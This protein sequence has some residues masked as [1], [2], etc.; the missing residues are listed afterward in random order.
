MGSTQAL[1]AAAHH[2]TVN[3]DSLDKI[4]NNIANAGTPGYQ[5]DNALISEYNSKGSFQD[6]LSFAVN[7]ASIRDVTPGGFIPTG[8]S[9]DIALGTP[10]VYLSV[11]SSSG[12]NLYT[13]NGHLELNMD[14]QIIHSASGYPLC[15]AGHSPI[16]IPQG[17]NDIQVASDGTISADGKMLGQIGVFKFQNSQSLSKMDN[18]LMKAS[19][20]PRKADHVVVLHRGVESSNVNSVISLTQMIELQRQ[21]AQDAAVIQAYKEQSSQQIEDL[22]TPL[23]V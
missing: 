23:N 3:R 1:L 4:A 12:D 19:E 14:R 6:S 5:A 16:T 2:M 15:D 21:D 11:K 13:R 7:K 22:I 9:M 10:D 8:S 20:D 17:A 18:T